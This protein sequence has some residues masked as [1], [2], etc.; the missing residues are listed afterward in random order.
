MGD[1]V[2]L[3][4]F[5]SRLMGAIHAGALE[6]LRDVLASDEAAQALHQKMGTD[7]TFTI[8]GY[9]LFELLVSP[10]YFES[11]A[12]S[13]EA[14]LA[15]LEIVGPH[16]PLTD[17]DEGVLLKAV[18]LQKTELLQKLLQLP[19]IDV[20][21]PQNVHVIIAAAGSVEMTQILLQCKDINVN[22]VDSDSWTP[23]MW[24]CHSG[25]AAVVEALLAVPNLNVPQKSSKAVNLGQAEF[26]A[27]VT[28]LDV[29]ERLGHSQIVASLREQKMLTI[30]SRR[31]DGD[32]FEVACATVAGETVSMSVSNLATV[33]DLRSQLGDALGV[34]EWQVKLL[35][36]ASPLGDDAVPLRSISL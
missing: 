31:D 14:I 1:D 2:A 11:S 7:R 26:P 20:N 19:G 22:V 30:T 5:N 25:H 21:R 10:S 35:V 23:L 9:A 34:S 33:G 24:A 27:G 32:A 36:E 16:F 4:E 17:M 15:I 28:A 3:E 18:D 12:S 6:D 13:T 8:G 29:A